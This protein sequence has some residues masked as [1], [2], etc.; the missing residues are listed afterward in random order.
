MGVG[1]CLFWL[2]KQSSTAWA[3]FTQQKIVSHRSGGRRTQTRVLAGSASGGALF[4]ATDC[5]FPVVS[6]GWEGK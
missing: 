1:L 3:A 5:R 4:G 2:L 6:L